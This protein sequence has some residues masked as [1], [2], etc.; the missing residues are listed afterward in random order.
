VKRQLKARLQTDVLSIE[1]M[2]CLL[3]LDT[4]QEASVAIWS[5][6]VLKNGPSKS[7]FI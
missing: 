6:A 7:L 1:G 5:N 3:L 4:N 2:R